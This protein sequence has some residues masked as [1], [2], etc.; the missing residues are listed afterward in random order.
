M[1]GRIRLAMVLHNHQ[2]VGNFDHVFKEA[3]DTSYRP[4]LD[5]L[6]EYPNISISLHNSG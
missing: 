2:P 3:Y 1:S 5:V 4:F 6:T